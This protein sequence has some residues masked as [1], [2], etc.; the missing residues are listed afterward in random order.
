MHDSSQ[1][2]VCCACCRE[3]LSAEPV[4]VHDLVIKLESLL[5]VECPVFVVWCHCGIYLHGGS[6]RGSTTPASVAALRTLFLKRR[7]ASFASVSLE[8]LGD[9]TRG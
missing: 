9:K 5:P 1:Y 3:N 8:F 7:T 6:Q 2:G 4:E